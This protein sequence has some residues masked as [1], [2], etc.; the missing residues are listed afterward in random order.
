L[1]IAANLLNRNFAMAAPNRA[2][3]GDITYIPT[4]EGWLFLAVVIDLFSRRVVGWSMQPEM[5]QSGHRCTGDGLVAAQSRILNL[6]QPFCNHGRCANL[7][8]ADTDRRGVGGNASA[9]APSV[10]L[11]SPQAFPER[12]PRSER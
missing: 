6:P 8:R 11:S 1:P 10:P 4:N 12:F 3:T 7:G 9:F 5:Q 2:W